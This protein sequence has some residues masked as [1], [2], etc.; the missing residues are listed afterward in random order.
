[1]ELYVDQHKRPTIRTRIKMPPV[2][3]DITFRR[4]NGWWV[5]RTVELTGRIDSGTLRSLPVARWEARANTMGAAP[6][7]PVSRPNRRDVDAWYR[8]LAARY[9]EELARTAAPEPVIAA[10][11]NAPTVTVARWVHDARK[12]GFLPPIPGSR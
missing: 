11:A 2:T 9:L 3:V 1:M 8:N 7:Y 6:A 4:H 12:R 5:I 10:E